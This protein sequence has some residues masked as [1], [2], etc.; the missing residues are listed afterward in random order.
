[1]ADSIDWDIVDSVAFS[2]LQG[3]AHEDVDA[4]AI[5]DCCYA[6]AVRQRQRL[7]RA[8][9]VLAACDRNETTRSRVAGSTSFTQRFIR[10]A[11][12]ISQTG[13]PDTTMDAILEELQQLRPSGAPSAVLTSL[14]ADGRPISLPFKKAS[15]TPSSDP[16]IAQLSQPTPPSNFGEVLAKIA[17]P[18]SKQE[19]FEEFRSLVLSL[20]S[21]FRLEVV[22][23]FMSSSIT[24]LLRMR[25]ST[26]TRLSSVIDVEFVSEIVGPSLVHGGPA[27]AS[28]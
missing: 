24:V 7:G 15:Q 25:W 18:G 21:Q 20:P 14:G 19:D 11:K 26:Y 13:A 28:S 17:I 27:P 5:L 2:G 8:C 1:M 3:T 9:Q 4:L 22:D 10:A 12:N 23:A 6:P 16:A